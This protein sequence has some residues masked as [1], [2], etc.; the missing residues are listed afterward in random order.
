MAVHNPVFTYSCW[1]EEAELTCVNWLATFLYSSRATKNGRTFHFAKK[2]RKKG[3]LEAKPLI[4]SRPEGCMYTCA[5]NMDSQ[6]V[7]ERKWQDAMM[8][9]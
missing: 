5:G 2:S 1:R 3:V 6:S 9:L 8:L 4:D 7:M